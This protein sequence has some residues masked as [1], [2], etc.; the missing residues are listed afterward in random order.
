M[1]NAY[2]SSQ[3]STYR[4]QA[5]L[6]RE[7]WGPTQWEFPALLPNMYHRCEL[8]NALF[9]NAAC[10]FISLMLGIPKKR[11]DYSLKQDALLLHAGMREKRA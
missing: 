7:G 2:S 6:E 3:P 8:C 10:R 5:R 9:T 4:S 11:D 1:L